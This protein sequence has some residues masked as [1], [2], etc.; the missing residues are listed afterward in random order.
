MHKIVAL[1]CMFNSTFLFVHTLHVTCRRVHDKS[2][3]EHH[4]IVLFLLH[5]FYLYNINNHSHYIFCENFLLAFS[6]IIC[7]VFAHFCDFIM[8]SR[9]Y[10]QF[11]TED[12]LMISA[13]QI[14]ELAFVMYIF[15]Y[16]CIEIKKNCY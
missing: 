15:I 1:T 8:F 7:V 12:C 13:L 5:I 9:F 16:L 14:C 6:K 3:Q 10:S 2:S 11:Y 4:I